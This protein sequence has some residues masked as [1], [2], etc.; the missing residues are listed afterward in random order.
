MSKFGFS[1]YLNA[2]EDAI[3]SNNPGMNNFKWNRSL[4]GQI[5]DNPV[6]VATSLSPMETRSFFSGIRT[7]A[8]DGTTVYSL[9]LLPLS[10]NTYV[11]SAVGGT[12][13]N[14]RIPR[15]IG[16]DAT[17]KATL[18]LNGPVMTLSAPSSSASTANFVGTIAGMT[19]PVTITALTAGAVG[20]VTIPAD[21]TSTI[22]QLIVNFNNSS[23]PSQVVLQ[24]GDDTQIPTL[25]ASFILTGGADA[26]TGITTSSIVIGDYVQLGSNFNILNQGNWQ[27]ISKTSNSVS[28]VNEGGANEGP[29]T[30]GSGFASQLNVFSADGVQIGDTLVISGGFS[31]VTQGAYK[32]TQ[33]AA[34]SLQFYMTG[35]LP[36]ESNIMTE[37]ISIY[38]RAKS[39]IYLEAASEVN[40][41]INGT[42][43]INVK[44][45]IVPGI[46]AATTQP[47]VLMLNS[48]IYSLSIQ[49]VGSASN[50]VFF[51]AVE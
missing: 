42:E 6:S 43:T 16:V 24:A 10:T 25:G 20:N 14:F 23:P 40:V 35:P 13:P 50:D 11:L 46:L 47:G 3:P 8:Q 51:A 33:V 18:S 49:N 22:N 30:L 1:V 38:S 34:N 2:Y 41:I 36:L 4:T 27:I 21:G 12:L 19:T 5:V 29:I 48:I 17:T 26:V 44:P 7:L 15:S 31:P 9:T 37:A 45:F 39:F 32:V 28:F